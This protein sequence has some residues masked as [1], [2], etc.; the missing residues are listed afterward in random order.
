M[1]VWHPSFAIFDPVAMHLTKP[2]HVSNVLCTG[3][4]GVRLALGTNLVV[5]TNA[6]ASRFTLSVPLNLIPI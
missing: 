6:D 5:T 4:A 3:L 1:D 2:Q